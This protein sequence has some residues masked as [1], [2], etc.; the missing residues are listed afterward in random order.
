MEA[1]ARRFRSKEERGFGQN[2]AEDSREIVVGTGNL[3]KVLRD[4]KIP[5]L[6]DIHDQNCTNKEIMDHIHAL[7]EKEKL[8]KYGKVNAFLSQNEEYVTRD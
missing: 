4:F 1:M 2:K 6:E 8:V 5:G 7:Q 3:N